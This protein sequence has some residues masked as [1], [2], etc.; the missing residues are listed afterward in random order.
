MKGCEGWDMYRFPGL[1]SFGKEGLGI[2]DENGLSNSPRL[3]IYAM[4]LPMKAVIK[5]VR[6]L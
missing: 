1:D 5:D 3:L 2:K 4:Q 6:W